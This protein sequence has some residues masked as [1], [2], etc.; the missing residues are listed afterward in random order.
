MDRSA[1]LVGDFLPALLAALGILVVGWVIALVVS[2]LVRKGLSRTTFDNKM[3]QWVTGGKPVAIERYVASVVFWVL[4]LFV[5]MAVFQTLNLATVAQ[6]VNALLNE[7]ATFLPRLGGAALLLALAWVVATVLKRLVGGVLHAANLDER[8]GADAQVDAA[9]GAKTVSVS[10]S[11]ANVV[12]WSVFLLFL[13]GILGALALEGLLAPVQSLVD[14]LLGFLPD[15]LGAALILLVGWFIAN[16]VRR[17]VTNLLA[18]VGADAFAD[19]MGVGQALGT[20]S[21]SGFVGLVVYVL[22]LLPVLIAALNALSLDAVT[23]PAS[24]MLG[25]ILNVIPALFGATILIAIAYFVG[26]IV[27]NLVATVLAGAGFDRIPAHLGLR[28][29]ADVPQAARPSQM[30]GSLLLVALM[31]FATIEAAEMIG[32]GV[33][34]S[35]LSR[36]LVLGGHVVLGLVIFG[37]GLYLARVAHGAVLATATQQA[38]LLALAARVSIIVLAGAMALRQMGLAN[39]IVNL[40]F[41]LLLGAIAVAAALAFGLGA[42]EVA[43]RTVERWAESIDKR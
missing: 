33:L 42:R 28:A 38:A 17:I 6:P 41:G 9:P 4:M 30:V 2:S 43:G 20:K 5:V 12:Y 31:L 34:A 16:L 3:A 40:A 14:S 21:L 39:E 1:V 19:R 29:G 32:F 23:A 13:P 36:F 26:R 37:V 18:A 27:S 15:L 10:D 24:E 11:L 25:S 7:I 8:L 35:L 22:I